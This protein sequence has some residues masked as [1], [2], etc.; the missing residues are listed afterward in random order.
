[1]SQVRDQIGY[2]VAWAVIGVGM[3]CALYDAAF[4]A[5]VQV[6]PTR[7]RRA[8]SYLTLYGAYA[9]TI[10][11]VIGHYLNEAYGWR[12]TLVIF[13]AIN[14]AICLPLNWIG[15][16]RR[17]PEAATETGGCR[18]VALTGPRS[19]AVCARSAS[20]CSPSSCR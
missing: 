3:R 19:K 7:G 10:F 6:V 2:F 14:L 5:L 20:R 4:A 1:L 18:D 16:S 8:I 13:A 12:G 17:E 11:W 15:L 9:S